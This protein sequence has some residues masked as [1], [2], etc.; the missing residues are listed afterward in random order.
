MNNKTYTKI[1]PQ[2]VKNFG[3]PVGLVAGYLAGNK[4]GYHPN[5]KAIVTHLRLGRSVVTRAL[6]K[7]FGADLATKD[8]NGRWRATQLLIK[9]TKADSFIVW[10]NILTD[11]SL[12]PAERLLLGYLSS[13]NDHSMDDMV[14]S[15]GMKK[16]SVNKHIASL[17]GKG[18][19]NRDVAGGGRGW[20]RHFSLAESLDTKMTSIEVPLVALTDEDE[21]TMDDCLQEAEAQLA[22]CDPSISSE[23]KNLAVL[24]LAEINAAKPSL[25]LD[26][27]GV[28]MHA[29]E[30][31]E[32]AELIDGSVLEVVGNRI[33]ENWSLIGNKKRY[34]QTALL[35]E[36][37]ALREL[38]EEHLCL[39]F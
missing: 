30:L 25:K 2:V 16:T 26:I 7:L 28:T 21:E 32:L 37:K 29:A 34:L 20:K 17:E 33:G 6:D 4:A 15:T 12:T 23:M 38:R 39:T 14:S 1:S 27:D 13:S 9:E 22:D 18:L 10:S 5:I 24:I 35:R 8:N 31:W 19:I 11:R 36:A 3:Y